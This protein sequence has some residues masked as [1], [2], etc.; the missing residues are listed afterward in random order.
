MS[1]RIDFTTR[2]LVKPSNEVKNHIYMDIGTSNFIISKKKNSDDNFI[3]DSNT[4][5]FDKNA[6]KASLNN[7]LHFK[8]G[9]SPLNPEF[10]I[11]QL[12]ELLYSVNDKYAIEKISKTMRS[13]I[14]TWEPRISIIS[15]PIEN[16][17]ETITITINY[18][19]QSL[20]ESDS[21]IYSFTR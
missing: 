14:S 17:D 21:F 1:L 8:T 16:T 3:L 10:G 15:M 11:G 12:Y 2:G 6:I 18:L 4:T 9:D 7:I 20:N 13:I 5:N 19:I